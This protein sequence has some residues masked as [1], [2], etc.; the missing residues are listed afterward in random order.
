[1][2]KQTAF[3]SL[4]AKLGEGVRWCPPNNHLAAQ[5]GEGKLGKVVEVTLQVAPNCQ[6]AKVA[7]VA[8]TTL[9]I[10]E[11]SWWERKQARLNK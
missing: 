9:A 6:G 1:M 2:S 7:N 4:A 3:C 8:F 11:P 5:L 10:S